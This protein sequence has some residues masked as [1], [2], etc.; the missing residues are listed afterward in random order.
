MAPIRIK[1]E[2]VGGVKLNGNED[3]R[4][5]LERRGVQSLVD[6]DGDHVGGFATLVDGSRYTLGPLILQQQPPQPQQAGTTDLL[7][8]AKGGPL[9]DSEIDYALANH[10]RYIKEILGITDQRQINGRDC[11]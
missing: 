9:T 5:W 8:E 4:A 7:E 2:G 6:S 11:D 3:L 1:V 10:S